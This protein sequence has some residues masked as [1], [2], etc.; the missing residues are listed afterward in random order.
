MGILCAR[1]SVSSYVVRQKGALLADAHQ[2]VLSVF[3]SKVEGDGDGWE[4]TAREVLYSIP[5]SSTYSMP[6]NHPTKQSASPP[7]SICSFLPA[8][9]TNHSKIKP[10]ATRQP[11][12]YGHHS[13]MENYLRQLWKVL[14]IICRP[15]HH[16]NSYFQVHTN[17]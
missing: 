11:Y 2:I 8:F 10:A 15:K 7:A 1:H 12:A 16:T 4:E 14:A 9:N 6:N 5:L 3:L 17:C 13:N